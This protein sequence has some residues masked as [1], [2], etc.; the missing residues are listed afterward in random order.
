VMNTLKRLLARALIG[1]MRSLGLVARATPGPQR[2]P[3]PT[4]R[5][6]SNALVSPWRV[7]R[8]YASPPH[9]LLRNEQGRLVELGVIDLQGP[10]FGYRLNGGKGGSEGFA[11]LQA[12]L[13]SVADLISSSRVESE[14]K[15]LPDYRGEQGVDP[16]N[17]E[18]LDI[19]LR[20]D[21]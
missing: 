2:A 10:L 16:D 7:Y 4:P 11:S 13:E 9:L 5:P 3:T 21:L 19:S 18:H 1:L 6:G 15:R 12:L 20:I 14:L 17:S 8:L